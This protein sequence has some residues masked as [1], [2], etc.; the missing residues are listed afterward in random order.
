MARD[1]EEFGVWGSYSGLNYEVDDWICCGPLGDRFQ[2]EEGVGTDDR[3]L[4]ING[5]DVVD[6]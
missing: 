3:F 2:G 5:F 1:P 6:G 4:N